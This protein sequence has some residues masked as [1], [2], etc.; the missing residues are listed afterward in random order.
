MRLRRV[1]LLWACL[2]A[3]VS[4]WSAC[5]AAGQTGQIHGK[6]VLVTGFPF[7]QAQ[8]ARW[9]AVQGME[10]RTP[11]LIAD[12]INST[13]NHLALDF[14]HTQIRANSLSQQ[15]YADQYP[16]SATHWEALDL[17]DSQFVLTGII[18]DVG[19]DQTQSLP[20]SARYTQK[21]L[22][23]VNERYNQPRRVAILVELINR[24]TGNLVWQHRY[25]RQGNWSLKSN[26]KVAVDDSRFWQSDYGRE[27]MIALNQLV[28]DVNTVLDCESYMTK[29]AQVT[30]Q[31]FF[32]NANSK[33]NIQ[34]GDYFYMSK[35]SNAGPYVP[36]SASR[37]S[38][39]Y[40]RATVTG[41]TPS[42]VQA[43]VLPADQGKVRVGD[44][45]T[46]NQG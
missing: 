16:R 33:T 9:G 41:V 2:L 8:Q 34:L 1:L 12:G 37:L 27:W 25:V 38:G 40:V 43:Q 23:W 45:V 7:L 11:Q 39:V 10:V 15:Y 35:L 44:L 46:V 31:G 6:S 29:V 28:E 18:E 24:Y 26:E 36:A 3:P 13:S 17:P 42:G 22:G 5:D 20:W 4:C 14:S 30:H 32:I 21:M 19:T